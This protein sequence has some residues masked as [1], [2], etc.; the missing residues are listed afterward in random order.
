[1]NVCS[2]SQNVVGCCPAADIDACNADPEDQNACDCGFLGFNP[3]SP[4]PNTGT[5]SKLECTNPGRPER[6]CTTGVCAGMPSAPAG[7]CCITSDAKIVASG[8]TSGSVCATDADCDPAP[9]GGECVAN[10]DCP[11]T[12]KCAL[13][14][15]NPGKACT[16]ANE[17]N[18]CAGAVLD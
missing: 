8:A 16:A 10:P 13:S 9:V 17:A 1:Q 3:G 6:P 7:A 15:T 14:S 5:I 18:V 2:R 11:Q 12:G 4:Y